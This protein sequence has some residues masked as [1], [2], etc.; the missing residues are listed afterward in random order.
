MG[1]RVKY[2]ALNIVFYSSSLFLK[3]A[4]YHGTAVLRVQKKS[5]L[6]LRWADR[7]GSVGRKQYNIGGARLVEKKISNV[8]AIMNTLL[9]Y[10]LSNAFNG[11]LGIRTLLRKE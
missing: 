1:K 11:L 3:V 5:S 10:T 8:V 4:V 7:L 6:A 9:R 2:I